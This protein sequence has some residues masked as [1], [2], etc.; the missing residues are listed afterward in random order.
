MGI[1]IFSTFF[2]L[3]ALII[4]TNVK[5]NE[6]LIGIGVCT[7]VGSDQNSFYFDSFTTFRNNLLKKYNSDKRTEF[8]VEIFLVYPLYSLACYGKYFFETM[9]VHY[10]NPNYVLITDN[11][12]YSIKKIVWLTIHPKDIGTYLKLIGEVIALIIYFLYLEIIQFT[13]CE[14]NFNT[15]INISERSKSE[16]LGIEIEEEEDDEDDDEQ[17][18]INNNKKDDQIKKENEMIEIGR[19]DDDNDN[20][21]EDKQ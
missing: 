4:T 19:T 5:C 11:I 9:V 14:M 7:S 18:D 10:L 8:F 21:N 2:T 20:D 15:S 17:K 3:L 13:C 6:K 16:T 12:Y 1:G